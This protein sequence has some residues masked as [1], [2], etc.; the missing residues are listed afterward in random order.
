MGVD[1]YII[2]ILNY[3]RLINDKFKILLVSMANTTEN[4][5]AASTVDAVPDFNVYL[6]HSGK[7]LV[8]I[9]SFLTEYGDVGFLRVVYESDGKET[10]RTIAIL[11]TS[12]YDALVKD[13]Y[14]RSQYGKDFVITVFELKPNN[15]PGEGRTKTL[16]VPVPKELGSNDETVVGTVSDKLKHLADWD[17]IPQDSWSVKVPLKS[18]EIGGVRGGCFVSFKRD[19]S[20]HRIAMVRVL[21]TDTYWP[22]HGD[23]ERLVF[24]CFWARD[25]K[26]RAPSVVKA[27]SSVAS[28]VGDKKAPKKNK[29]ESDEKS[30]I[31]RTIGKVKPP[32]APKPTGKAPAK[33]KKAPAMPAVTQPAPKPAAE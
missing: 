27:A 7:S 10:N 29:K 12:S 18:R 32:A 20:I 19:V 33:G 13:G 23:D 25:R 31:Q 16:F 24:R 28:A 6:I 30:S 22:E 4:A 15:Y 14:G 5:G 21:L 2:K 17:I 11:P 3:Y 9:D 26:P 8:S 1:T